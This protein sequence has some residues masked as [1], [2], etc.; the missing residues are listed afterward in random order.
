MIDYNLIRVKL[1]ES[2]K[3]VPGVIS[4]GIGRE[5]G[6]I[7]LIVAIDSRVF[8]GEV[9]DSFEGIDVITRD[10]G[11][12]RLHMTDGGTLCRLILLN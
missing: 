4:I 5:D 8:T 9:P 6:K 10:L 7:V 2:L 1:A 12:A 11:V 3:K